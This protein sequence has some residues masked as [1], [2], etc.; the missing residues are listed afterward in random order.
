MES[1]PLVRT[2]QPTGSGVNKLIRCSSYHGVENSRYNDDQDDDSEIKHFVQ[3]ETNDVPTYASINATPPA[4]S[5]PT[6][7]PDNDRR[8][9]SISS[10]NSSFNR[11]VFTPSMEDRLRRRL[12]FHFMNPCD[13]W[14]SRRRFPWKLILQLL[15]VFLVTFQLIV[16]GQTRSR[17][18]DFL[19]KNIITF[20]HLY[21]CGWDT[22]FET[23]PYPAS[24][25]AFA[26]YT[27][28]EIVKG[29]NYA[30][31]RYNA[32]KEIA[33]GSYDFIRT[34]N[35]TNIPPMQLIIK[36]Y[37]KGDINPANQTYHYDSRI[38]QDSFL[39]ES[40]ERFNKSTNTTDEFFDLI[41][42]LRQKDYYINFDSLVDMKLKF[43]LKTIHL[44][45]LSMLQSPDCFQFDINIHYENIQHDGQVDISL[46]SDIFKL[47]CYGHVDHETTDPRLRE[48]G[49][50]TLDVLVIIISIFSTVLCFR[51]LFRAEMLRRFTN[52]F[53]EYKFNKKLSTDDMMEFVNL[54]HI[55]IIIN[56]VLT[57]IGTVI[58]MAIDAS[59]S[60]SYDLCGLLLGTGNLLIWI[61][62]LR[63]LQFFK[64][65]NLLILTM[66]A[67][68]PAILRFLLCA[69]FFYLGFT[70]CGWIVLGPYHVKFRDLSTA[71]ECL[72][73]LV[74]GDDMFVTFA[75]I[76]RSNSLIYIYSRVYLYIF[77]SLFMY[78]VYSIFT[79]IIIT[80]YEAIKNY[81]EHG[82][83]I[84]ELHEF[85]NQDPISLTSPLYMQDTDHQCHCSIFS[86]CFTCCCKTTNE[87][88]DDY[89]SL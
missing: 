71:S 16:F 77:I 19:E 82:F 47:E 36:H 54:W 68:F 12:R 52:K 31:Y 34:R 46:T 78:V 38:V 30:W 17:H 6:P 55:L 80:T 18:V 86:L 53:F 26:V 60:S 3:R 25:G 8:R 50:R 69:A 85:I 79:S 81:Y 42:F 49:V 29:V 22:T 74:N 45:A 48:Y 40:M 43:S 83:P 7:T 88:P 14:K 37:K 33:I 65:Y 24:H 1:Q 35:H 76:Q 20:K 5:T 23:M 64:H 70:F 59:E 89:S 62:V 11:S 4:T 13:K 28:D 27:I 41:T 10:T 51:S 9:S 2:I 63:Y 72:F 21:L 15:K 57:V 73:S 87:F 58:K 32:T 56:D 44:K 66:K 75:A 84:T 61:G 39:L 67:A